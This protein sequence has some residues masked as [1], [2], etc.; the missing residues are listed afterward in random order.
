MDVVSKNKNENIK[1][2]IND[3]DGVRETILE[4]FALGIENPYVSASEPGIDYG[5]S[6]PNKD[7]LW[8]HSLNLI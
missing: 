2:I 4:K 8:K 3:A 6:F 1:L 7:F 5:Q